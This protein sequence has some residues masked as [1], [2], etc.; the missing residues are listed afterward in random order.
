MKAS[1]M[2]LET[3]LATPETALLWEDTCEPG[4]SSNCEGNV[5]EMAEGET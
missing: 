1:L 4:S 3:G 5:L 2:F